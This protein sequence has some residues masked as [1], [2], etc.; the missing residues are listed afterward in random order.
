[1]ERSRRQPFPNNFIPV[2]RRSNV[3]TA[4]LQYHPAP[5]FPGIV[6]NTIAAPAEPIQDNR[7]AGGKA[8]HIFNA[9]HRISFL[10]N[11]TDRPA[12][13]SGS[14]PLP[15]NDET[16]TALVNYTYQRVA[17]EGGSLQLRQHAGPGNHEPCRPRLFDVPQSVRHGGKGQR[18]E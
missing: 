11:F 1:M 4:M 5:T 10:Y 15:V 8:D 7:H 14:F 9:N 2:N 18:L 17:H 6:A 16:A 12:Q 3:S 13:K